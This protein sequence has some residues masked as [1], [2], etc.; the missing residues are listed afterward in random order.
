MDREIAGPAAH[1]KPSTKSAQGLMTS[2]P[3]EMSCSCLIM[4]TLTQIMERRGEVTQRWTEFRRER[5]Y[6]QGQRVKGVRRFSTPTK[7]VLTVQGRHFLK[8]T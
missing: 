8:F 5:L 2:Q 6:I 1:L 4:E 7:K 3:S